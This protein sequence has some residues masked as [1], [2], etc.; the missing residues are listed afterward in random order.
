MVKNHGLSQLE[1]R[2]KYIVERWQ[3][4][5]SKAE[6]GNEVNLS[7]KQVGRVIRAFQENGRLKRKIGSGRPKALSRGLK[8][9][10]IQTLKKN[11]YHTYSTLRAEL[12]IPAT[13]RT[14]RNYLHSIG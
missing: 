2:N 8:R 14:I 4:G 10:I 5:A 3:D 1:A 6:I 13:A 11:P 12:K 7:S 9:K